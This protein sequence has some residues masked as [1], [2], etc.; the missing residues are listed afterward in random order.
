V[1]FTKETEKHETYFV[2]PSETITD[3]GKIQIKNKKSGR[4][5]TDCRKKRKTTATRRISNKNV[6]PPVI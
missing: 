1:F 2:R 4:I 3:R 5:F 6:M